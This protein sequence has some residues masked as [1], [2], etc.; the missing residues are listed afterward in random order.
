MML[1]DYLVYPA[2][3]IWWLA[4]GMAGMMAN[5][6]RSAAP[7][8]ADTITTPVKASHPKLLVALH[9]VGFTVMYV[10]IANAVFSHRIPAWF[11]GHDLAGLAVI[12][13]SAA[14]FVWARL[15]FRSWRLQARLETGHELATGGPFRW[16]RHP[17]Y[18][19]VTLLALGTALW[20]PTPI[21]WLAFALMAI[22]SDLRARAEEKVL[23]QGFGETYREYCRKTARFVPGIY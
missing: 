20:I 7:A 17:I 6:G 5:R 2:H 21:L 14:M 18:A 23:E 19:S 22:G 9:A 15:Y 3:W 11:A 1:P 12:L 13:L 10:G 8:A 16:V 4:F